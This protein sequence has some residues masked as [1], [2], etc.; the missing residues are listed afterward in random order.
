MLHQGRLKDW[1]P[2]QGRGLI[3]RDKAGPDISICS[4][5]F[6]KKPEQLQNGDSIFSDRSRLSRT[7]HSSRSL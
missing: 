7:A 4:S 6:R 2:T 1:N 3:Q 5:G